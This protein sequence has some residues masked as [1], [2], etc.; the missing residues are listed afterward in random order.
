[1]EHL[2]VELK[3]PSVSIGRDELQQI[4]DYA[5]AVSTDERFNQPNVQWQFW[6][7]G[8]ELHPFVRDKADS[9]DTPQ[10]VAAQGRRYRVIA[11]TWAEVIT[12]AKHRLKFFQEALRMSSTKAD[13]LEYLRQ[14]HAKL[15][16]E[17]LRV[18]VQ[19]IKQRSAD[20]VPVGRAPRRHG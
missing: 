20:D 6:I 19:I 1:L 14:A 13:G 11:K 15:L 12:D 9:P 5:Y 2:V 10:G 17:L 3:R 4:E 8:N 18:D 7:I 16:P